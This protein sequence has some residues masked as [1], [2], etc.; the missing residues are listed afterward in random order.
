MHLRVLKEIVDV[1]AESLSCGEG[2]WGVLMDKQL[3]KSLQCVLAAQKANGILGCIKRGVVIRERDRIVPLYSALVRTH[4]EYC[5]PTWGTQ[6][7]SF[8]VSCKSSTSSQS[9]V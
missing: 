2:L 4:P 9:T 7:R 1:L 5:V 3:H 8:Q 6:N